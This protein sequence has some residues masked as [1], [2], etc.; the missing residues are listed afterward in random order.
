MYTQP[1]C[2]NNVLR[3]VIICSCLFLAQCSRTRRTIKKKI[4]VDTDHP[5]THYVRQ[6]NQPLPPVTVWIHA[7]ALTE[8][9][10]FIIL[11]NAKPGLKL[12]T[13]IDP[14][15]YLTN[16]AKTLATYSPEQFPLETFYI[17]GWSG[18]LSFDERKENATVLP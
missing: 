9:P 13:H 7:P 12:V 14:K 6:N 17:Y 10:C 11:F 15:H 4:M 5:I 3:Y 18:K 16:A 8:I 2:R 1:H